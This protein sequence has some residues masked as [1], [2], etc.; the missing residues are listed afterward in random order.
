MKIGVSGTFDVDNFGDL[1]FPIIVNDKLSNHECITLSPTDTKTSFVDALPAQSIKADMKGLGAL[2]I[3]GGNVIHTSNS[4][5]DTYVKNNIGHNAYNNI[6]CSSTL[7]NKNSSAPII[8]NCPGVAEK[9]QVDIEDKLIT[10]LK[11]TDYLSVRDEQSKKIILSIYPEAEVKVVPDSAWQLPLVFSKYEDS[12]DLDDEIAK[13]IDSEYAVFHFNKRY[14]GD[15]SEE[16]LANYVDVI[17]KEFNLKPILIAIGS[18]HDD[19]VINSNISKLVKTPHVCISKLTSIYG[20]VQLLSRCKAYFGSSMHGLITASSYGNAAICIANGKVKFEGIQD[21]FKDEQVIYSSWPELIE[22]LDNIDINNLSLAS[23]L[24][25][26]DAHEKLEVHWGDIRKIID[27]S[28][29][30]IDFSNVDRV[31]N[32]INASSIIRLSSELSALTKKERKNQRE[33]KSLEER[34]DKLEKDSKALELK[35]NDLNLEYA[36]LSKSYLKLKSRYTDLLK[37]TNKIQFRLLFK[38]STLLANVKVLKKGVNYVKGIKHKLNEKGT[39]VDRAMRVITEEK[40]WDVKDTTL[41]ELKSYNSKA[42]KRF[43][44]VTALYGGSDKLM[45]P[46]SIRDDFDYFCFSDSKLDTFG[47]WNICQ[48]PYY[49][50][51]PARMARYVKMHLNNLFSDYDAVI[52]CD[53]NIRFDHSVYGLFDNFLTEEYDAKFI[54]HPHRDCIYDEAEACLSL[55]KDDKKTINQQIERYT[56]LGIKKKAGMYETGLYFIKTNLDNV[57]RFYQFWWKE[58][59]LGSRRDQISIVPAIEHSNLKISSLFES[60]ICVRTHSGCEIIPH[61]SFSSIFSPNCLDE[62]RNIK[63]PSKRDVISVPKVSKSTDVIICVYNA[64]EDVQ[65]CIESVVRHSYGSINK[66]IIVNDYSDDVTT[67]Y[68]KSVE[69]RY[70]KICLINNEVNLGYTKSAN[71][72]LSSSK[73]DFRIILNSDTIVTPDWVSKLSN[74]AFQSNNVGIVGPISNAAGSQSVPSVKGT[75][76]QTAINKLPDGFSIDDM[77]DIASVNSGNTTMPSVPLIHGFCI[78]IKS[79]VIQ[80]IGYFDDVNFARYYGEE[81]DY[82]LRA[83]RAG[84]ELIVATDT[85]IFHSKSKSIEEEERILHMSEAGKRLRDIYG[86]QEMRDYCLQLDM[87]SN[88]IQVRDYFDLKC[89]N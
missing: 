9:F 12:Q 28:K 18:C 60:G 15:L 23:K 88:L 16:E 13:I 19:E 67:K 58:I 59:V 46:R 7:S 31:N 57:D 22:N 63:S 70:D 37:I 51:D 45:L 62:F 69:A 50:S 6:W 10:C 77:N 66:I 78:G 64:L 85:Y 83:Y 81:N 11:N 56:S 48:S 86:K 35:Y 47:L 34:S 5:L 72:G 24:V 89:Y 73:A 17:S 71:V 61:K 79:E 27:D 8:W 21:L 75:K 49:H 52:W 41:I 40:Y 4:T 14:T 38:V 54:E 76:G 25:S 82:C 33:L 87:N 55:G 20:T 74:V 26:K 65:I 80:E 36:K 30:D 29:G 43:A 68:L 2:V 44:V 84:F 53:A 32:E 42:K 39:P 1:L 3:G